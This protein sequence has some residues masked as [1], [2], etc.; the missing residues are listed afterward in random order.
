MGRFSLDL[1]Y[2]ESDGLTI[3]IWGEVADGSLVFSVSARF[4]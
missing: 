1:G 3:P 2:Y 4:P